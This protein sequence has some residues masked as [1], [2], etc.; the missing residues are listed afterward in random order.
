MD[1]AR[2]ATLPTASIA[3]S[4]ACIFAHSFAHVRDRT[5][6][7]TVKQEN[8]Q[9]TPVSTFA[10]RLKQAREAAG[11]KSQAAL[12]KAMGISPGSIGNWETGIRQQPRD[13]LPLARALG[14]SPYWLSGEKEESAE[15][16]QRRPMFSRSP[17]SEGAIAHPMSQMGFETV[18]SITWE[19]L[20]S[21]DPKG[22]FSALI[23]D[24]AMAPRVRAGTE[25]FFKTDI[26]ARP[27]A[28]VLVRDSSG[29]VYLREYREAAGGAWEAHAANPAYRTLHSQADGLRVLA[30]LR[31]VM[32]GWEEI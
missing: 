5:S 2:A 9:I 25:C 15:D 10:D 7:T 32:R 22:T 14:V 6:L 19:Q 13:L 31:G 21:A 27:G 23:P 26:P 11:F 20:M 4:R 12:A 1:D 24:D 17:P 28:G 3:L 18:P 8:A 30:V 29:A 16:V